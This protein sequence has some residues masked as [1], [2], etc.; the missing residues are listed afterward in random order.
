VEKPEEILRSSFQP[1][2]TESGSTFPGILFT[3][4]LY[5]NPVTKLTGPV[6]CI[7]TAV[8]EARTTSPRE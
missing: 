5:A 6:R 1:P 7:S 3:I 2:E 4:G 8:P